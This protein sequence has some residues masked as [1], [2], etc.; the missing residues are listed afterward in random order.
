MRF[1]ASLLVA[2]AL[3]GAVCGVGAVCSHGRFARPS[4][5]VSPAE[6]ELDIVAARPDPIT[7]AAP[8]AV[9]QAAPP[10]EPVAP[11]P[12]AVRTS[13]ARTLVPAVTKPMEPSARERVADPEPAA[14]DEPATSE[15]GSAASAVSAPTVPSPVPVAMTVR[16]R[17]AAPPSR[18]GNRV[19]AAPLY[20][21][22]PPPEYPIPSRRRGEEG[23]VF[24]DVV[25]QTDGAP[26]S[27]TLNRSSGYPL[28]DRAALD[29]VRGW[30]FEPARAAG[31]PVASTV[32]VPVRFSL[33]E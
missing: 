16:A 25:V 7:E 22:N 9:T 29:A 27:V 1:T 33:S 11:A 19:S 13:V 10:A 17:P 32:V 26:S 31:V 28:L 20:R 8:I 12:V 15:P 3:H 30:S 23:V 4:R 14:S 21:R 24:L 18:G 2:A 6:I 5:I